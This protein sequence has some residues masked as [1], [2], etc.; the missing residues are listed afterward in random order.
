MDIS[1][2]IQEIDIENYPLWRKIVYIWVLFLYAFCTSDSDLFFR[3]IF[4]EQLNVNDIEPIKRVF[5][6]R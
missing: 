1:F 2:V 3:N 4:E 6:C 5:A